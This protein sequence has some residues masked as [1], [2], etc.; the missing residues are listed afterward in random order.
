[1]YQL[2][3]KTAITLLIG[4][5]GAAV[6]FASHLPMPF[7]LGAILSVSMAAVLGV[8]VTV[9]ETVRLPMLV[10]FGLLLGSTITPH[11]LYGAWINFPIVLLL[12]PYVLFVAGAL[13]WGLKKFAGFESATAFFSAV[14]GGVNE[15]MLMGKH[16]NADERAL[17]VHQTVRLFLVVTFVAGVFQLS[18]GMV[19]AP[20][21]LLGMHV[22]TPRDYGMQLAIGALGA[23]VA[24][25]IRVPAGVLLGP[26]VLNAIVHFAGLTAVKPDATLALLAQIVVGAS[27]GQRFAAFPPPA[28]LASARTA[29]ISTVVL[30][31]ASAATAV[32]GSLISGY[33]FLLLFLAFSPGGIAEM[34]L[35]ALS[36]GYDAGFVS[37][38]QICRFMFSV[39]LA[40][41]LYRFVR[42]Y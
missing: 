41:G 37:I 19:R 2:A 24:L 1:L 5:F 42:N 31:A 17:A 23:G 39:S 7:L 28:L 33:P 30:L 21:P 27:I 36:A 34:G 22:A 15:M 4:I 26:F 20:F 18:T 35:I 25:L 10:I 3:L 32:I 6:A 8:A 13:Y 40:A 12:L 29:V 38:M 11:L 14:P 16:Y 9:P